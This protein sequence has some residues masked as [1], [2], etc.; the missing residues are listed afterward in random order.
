MQRGNQVLFGVLDLIVKIAGPLSRPLCP[1]S[2]SPICYLSDLKLTLLHSEWPKFYGV[3]AV[4]SAIGLTY[5]S[6][7][8]LLGAND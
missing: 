8:K 1:R 4:Q 7:T 3:L 5:Q 6:L 2:N